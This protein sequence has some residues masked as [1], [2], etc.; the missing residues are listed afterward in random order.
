MLVGLCRRIHPTSGHRCVLGLVKLYICLK[1]TNYL[2]LT[3]I[4][5]GYRGVIAIQEGE[6][7]DIMG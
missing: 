6:V 1:G 2:A 5:R 7:R 3:G 4:K